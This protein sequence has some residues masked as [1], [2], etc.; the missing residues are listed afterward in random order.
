MENIISKYNLKNI[1]VLKHPLSEHYLTHLRDKTTKPPLFRTLTKKISSLLA[2]EA[3]FDLKTKLIDI[4][5]P[6]EK[7]KGKIIN[8]KIIVIPILRAGIGMIEPLMDLFPNVKVGYIG[9]QRDEE[10][11]KPHHYYLKFP[12]IKNKT[13]FVTDPMLATGGS[14]STAIEKIKKYEPRKIILLTIVSAPEGIKKI[15]EDHPDVMI[16]TASIDKKLNDKKYILPGLG[17]FGDRLYGTE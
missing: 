3:S 9:I 4:E 10:T 8:E 7:T 17:D 14:A 12:D 15:N 2:L 11:A 5:T 1:I 16:Y 13:V 6:L